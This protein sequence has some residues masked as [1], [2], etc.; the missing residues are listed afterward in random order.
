M[1]DKELKR[2]RRD[3]L[4]EL[5]IAQAEENEKLYAKLEEAQ[6]ALESKKLALDNAGTLADAAISVNGIFNQADAAATQYLENIQAMQKEQEACCRELTEQAKTEAARLV[7]E[8]KDYADQRRSEADAY[9]DN[10]VKNARALYE[11]SSV[12]R[13]GSEESGQ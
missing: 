1:A 10:A 13:Q 12:F 4:L 5:L 8:A 3:E 6:S 9:W 7:S 2:L 11:A